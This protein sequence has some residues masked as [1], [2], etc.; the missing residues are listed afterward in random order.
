MERVEEEEKIVLETEENLS[1]RSPRASRFASIEQHPEYRHH[2]RAESDF[3]QSIN[4]VDI[5]EPSREEQPYPLAHQ[6]ST[7]NKRNIMI[8]DE[9]LNIKEVND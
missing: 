1:Q 3:R 4:P 5:D 6:N 7:E 8:Q 2:N 9:E